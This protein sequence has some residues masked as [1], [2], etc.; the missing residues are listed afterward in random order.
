M[1]SSTVHFEDMAAFTRRVSITES[2][3]RAALRPYVL[4][5]DIEGLMPTL[6]AFVMVNMLS[7]QSVH[8]AKGLAVIVPGSSAVSLLNRSD[9]KVTDLF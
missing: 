3:A 8:A 5:I 7:S 2:D 4:T 1:P 6:R 9:A